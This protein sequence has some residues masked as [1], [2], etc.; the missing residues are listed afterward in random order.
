MYPIQKKKPYKKIIVNN[1]EKGSTIMTDEWLANKGFSKNYIHGIVNHGFG[2]YVNGNNYT[3]TIVKFWSLFKRG[4]IGQYHQLSKK[5]LNE[6]LDEFC[7]RY[8]NRKIESIFYLVI[9]KGVSIQ[10]VN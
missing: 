7:F 10:W 6:Y 1:I 8:N 5:Y 9:T 3:N 2:E 4:F